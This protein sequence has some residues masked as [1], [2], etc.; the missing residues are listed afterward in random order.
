MSDN[1]PLKDQVC[2]GISLKD[3]NT[4]TLRQQKKLNL[5]WLMEIYKAYPD[6]EHFFNAYFNKLAGNDTLKK[7][8]ITGKTEAEIRES[9]EPALSNFKSLRSKYLL[10]K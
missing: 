8:L 6:K 7:Q 2:Y 10:Y 1:P 4:D 9:W 3:Y 5:A